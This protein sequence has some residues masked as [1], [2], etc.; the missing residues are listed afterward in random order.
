MFYGGF[1]KTRCSIVSIDPKRFQVHLEFRMW[2]DLLRDETSIDHSSYL[3]IPDSSGGF[4]VYC[5]VSRLGLRC[6][7]MQYGRV[8][9]Y[10]SKQLETHEL[11]YPIHDLELAVI[12]FSLKIWQ[13]YLYGE[14]FE[15][16]TDRKSLKYLFT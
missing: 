14:T 5:D 15:I 13:H 9:I 16:F 2:R 4:I 11:N 1:L 8:V 6:V 10:G 3:T 7:L 12:V